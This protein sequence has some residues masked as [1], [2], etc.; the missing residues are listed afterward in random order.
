AVGRTLD[1]I[2]IDR[3]VEVTGVRRR[4]VRSGRP[5]GEWKFEVGDVVVL[6]GR[7]GD[8]DRAESKLLRGR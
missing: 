8:L 6:L 3:R 5:D 2:A 7:P 1:D 4:G